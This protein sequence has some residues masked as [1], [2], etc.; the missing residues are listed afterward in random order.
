M[1]LFH[2]GYQAIQTRTSITGEKTLTLA[3]ASI[4][5]MTSSFA[6]VGPRSEGV[7]RCT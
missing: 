5:L 2:A 7:N 4:S 3:R 1:N 6:V